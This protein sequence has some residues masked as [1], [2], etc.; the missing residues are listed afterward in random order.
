MKKN[1][2]TFILAPSIRAAAVLLALCAFTTVSR[3]DVINNLP[4]GVATAISGNGGGLPIAQVFTMSG[5]DSGTV[6]SLT[7]SLDF[8]VDNP[9]ETVT[10]SLF[11]VSGGVPT[12]G[13]GTVLGT[14]DASSFSSGSPQNIT[15][16]LSSN[17]AL[18]AGASYA[19][20]LE[21][22]SGG[23]VNWNA[24]S[25]SATGGTATSLGGI[26]GNT[27]ADGS[28]TWTATGYSGLVYA[29]MD[30]QISSVPEVPLTGTVM[31]FGA[32][33]IA[34]GLTLRRKLHPVA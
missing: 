3:A 9:S 4:P 21:V 33:A 7:L 16:T 34:V 2:G 1:L 24:T 17:P 10:V 19:I 32:V 30:L 14:F 12:S 6:S 31:G 25:T 11:N 20:A 27:A 26:Y 18:S 23:S 29:Q 22:P 28:G 15:L 13:S 8:V 5:S